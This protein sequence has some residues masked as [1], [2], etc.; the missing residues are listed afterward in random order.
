VIAY[1]DT[2]ALVPLLVSE[3]SSPTCSQL[4][5]EATRVISSRLVYPEA[6]AALAQAERMQRLTATELRTAVEDLNSL[7]EE[8]DY[9]EVTASLAMSAGQFAEAHALRGYDAVHLASANAANDAELV[10]VTGDQHLRSAAA[11][12]GISVALTTG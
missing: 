8:I 2:S 4:W 1:F 6:R 10:L 5:N 11:Q 12:I 9:L 7:V 3:P